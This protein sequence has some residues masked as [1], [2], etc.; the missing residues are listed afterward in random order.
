MKNRKEE[1]LPNKECLISILVEGEWIEC[2]WKP[3][4]KENYSDE[5]LPSEGYL[6]T[7]YTLM[8]P[9]IGFHAWEQNDSEFLNYK[10]I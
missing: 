7:A 3:Y 2:R 6:G 8:S 4:K 9:V 1:P 10:L 5:L